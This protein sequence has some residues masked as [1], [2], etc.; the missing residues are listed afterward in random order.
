MHGFY[1]APWGTAREEAKKHGFTLDEHGRMTT[2][3]T[4]EA[5]LPFI[6][7]L[8]FKD[9]KLIRGAIFEQ[10]PQVSVEDQGKICDSA[11]AQFSAQYGKPDFI[12]EDKED[13]P[14]MTWENEDTTAQLGCLVDLGA[15]RMVIQKKDAPRDHDTQPAA[16]LAN[17]LSL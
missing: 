11:V 14:L 9:G 15:I 12:I 16:P 5:G 7:F 3:G 2:S 6:I 4:D 8:E 1:N 17:T 10:L 13:G